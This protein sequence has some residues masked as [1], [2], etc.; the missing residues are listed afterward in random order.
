[1]CWIIVADFGFK[2]NKIN[3]CKMNDVKDLYFK[4]IKTI[5]DEK[6]W[7]NQQTKYVSIHKGIKKL[8]LEKSSLA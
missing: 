7:P 2:P 1:M 6:K 8:H 3:F 4:L 5:P